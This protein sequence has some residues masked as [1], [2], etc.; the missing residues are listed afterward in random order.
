MKGEGAT[1]LSDIGKGVTIA[2]RVVGAYIQYI[3]H[4]L[5]TALKPKSEHGYGFI[6]GTRSPD[7]TKCVF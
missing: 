5:S 1:L 6:K 4:W 7:K 2:R 3:G